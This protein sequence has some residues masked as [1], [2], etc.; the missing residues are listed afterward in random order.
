M[1][2][3]I[4]LPGDQVS[5]NA[6]PSASS[7]TPLRLGSGL[8]LLHQ[9]QNK[10]KSKSPSSSSS[11][12]TIEATHAGLLSIDHIRK[13]VSI[14]TFPNRRY[15]PT[16]NDL[17]IAQVQRS[18]TDFFHC[19]V[20]PHAPFAVLGQLAFEGASKKTRPNLKQGDLVYARVLSIG[21]GAGTEVELTCVNPTTGKA[22]PGGLGLLSGGMLFDVSTGLAA[23]LM[24]ASTSSSS[25]EAASVV[26]LEELG[27]KLE[28]KGGFELAVGRNGKVWVDSSNSGDL[29]VKITVAIGNFGCGS[30]MGQTSSQ[31]TD[32]NSAI[33]KLYSQ[34][35]ENDGQEEEEEITPVKRELENNAA[36]QSTN[37]RDPSLTPKR[38]RFPF[39]IRVP[40]PAEVLTMAR[41]LNT[42]RP[43]KQT[44]TTHPAKR[45]RADDP[46]NSSSPQKEDTSLKNKKKKLEEERSLKFRPGHVSAINGKKTGWFSPEEVRTLENF[47]VEFCNRHGITPEVFDA[48]V[49]SSLKNKGGI[50]EMNYPPMTYNEF[51]KAICE[52]IPDR[53]RRS[54]TRFMRR[55][56]QSGE[57]K[58]HQWAAEDDDELERLHQKYGT[59]WAQIA[60]EMQRTHDDVVQRWKNKVEHRSTMK[61]GSWAKDEIDRL[62]EAIEATYKVHV[63]QGDK[64]KVGKDIYEMDDQYISWGA[65]SDRLGNTRSRQQCADRWRKIR[66]AVKYLRARGD[67]NAVFTHNLPRKKRTPP[68]HLAF[69]S[70]ERVKQSSDEEQSSSS[71]S[72]DSESD[73]ASDS[74]D[75][76]PEEDN[77]TPPSST[78]R[79][80]RGPS[81]LSSQGLGANKLNGTS[82]PAIRKGNNSESEPDDDSNDSDSDSSSESDSSS[83][84]DNDSDSDSDS[85]DADGEEQV[86]SSK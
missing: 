77:K 20:T 28:S 38:N 53:D 9:P 7:K 8:R 31:I 34:E 80:K 11:Q 64:K 44:E 13:S 4:V 79:S 75:T 35:Q 50:F 83:N 81:A 72:S 14:Q 17:I 68:S 16:V 2:T 43:E 58:P 12:T 74:S 61:E 36:T 86:F 56:F 1:S 26:V 39:E 49:Q 6:L 41:P 48:S 46:A 23:R 65:I 78:G 37:E 82:S 22:E 66:R 69:K 42:P 19:I 21:I 60:K 62:L 33:D 24:K 85:D 27:S 54:T 25:A 73:G 30:T 59:K 57:K 84:K 5:S 45:K 10:A 67:K 29:A 3:S 55:H 18:S 32:E 15:I 76:S 47:K 70:A 51:W 63:D 52:L 40:R 71:D